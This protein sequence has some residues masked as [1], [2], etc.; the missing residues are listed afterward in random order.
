MTD[1]D[2]QL[3]VLALFL[4][5]A[6]L[7]L[8]MRRLSS[9]ERGLRAPA[10][11]SDRADDD[12]SMDAIARGLPLDG[13]R[14]AKSVDGGKLRCYTRADGAGEFGFRFV[15]EIDVAGAAECMA[16]PRETDLIPEWNIFCEAAEI[17][18]LDSPTELW[19]QAI[20]KLPW[21]VPRH[22]VRLHA[23]LHDRVER[24]GCFVCHTA[25]P[26]DFPETSDDP[27]YAACASHQ[28]PLRLGVGRLVPLPEAVAGVP[29]TAADIVMLIDLNQVRYL[30]GLGGH[31]PQWLVDAVLA[32]MVPW[33]WRMALQLLADMG[34][35]NALA[36][37]LRADESG[38][39]AQIRRACRQ[40]AVPPREGTM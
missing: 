9:V 27:R 28:L 2:Q 10:A 3:R 30:R 35:D 32:I 14:L 7:H 36:R 24:D 8:I 17:V 22:L 25:S 12:L 18:R 15:S 1:P 16:L 38:V 37:R 31:L 39:Y 29:R 20:L 34:G 6:I 23:T 26:P 33:L 40:P 4:S 5:C 21:P 11:S 19:A 13:W